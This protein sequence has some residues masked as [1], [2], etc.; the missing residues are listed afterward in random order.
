MSMTSMVTHDKMRVIRLARIS[1]TVERRIIL[2]PMRITLTPAVT[3]LGAASFTIAS[4]LTNIFF[5]FFLGMVEQLR[6]VYVGFTFG[7]WGMKWCDILVKILIIVGYK[8]GESMAY[9]KKKI[10]M[11]YD[12]FVK[13]YARK[14]KG[15]NGFDPNDR[16]YDRKLEKILKKMKPEDLCEMLDSDE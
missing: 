16:N 1:S 13:Q 8:R 2:G 4:E 12:L 6:F 5:I 3:T 10:K 11:E 14:G 9:N 7:L 15:I